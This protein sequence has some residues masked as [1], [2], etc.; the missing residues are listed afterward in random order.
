M[1]SYKNILIVI[2]TLFGYVTVS[3][4]RDQT[5]CKSFKPIPGEKYVVSGW[6][7]EDRGQVI[8]YSKGGIKIVFNSGGDKIFRTSGDI[9]DG[10]QR[11][12]GVF[13]VPNDATTIGIG[14]LSAEQGVDTY[15]DDIRIYPFNGNIKS[16]VYDKDTQRL[17]AEL[18]ENNYATFYEYDQEGGL[19]RVKKETEKG[20]Y[21]IQETRSGTSKLT[22]QQQ[23]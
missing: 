16:F 21:T 7:K 11:V 8:S 14:F 15:Y 19:V 18:D 2:L 9:I 4:Q 10:W 23:P 13:Q 12:I 1:I 20:V 3:A 5:L 22:N 17:M 6:L